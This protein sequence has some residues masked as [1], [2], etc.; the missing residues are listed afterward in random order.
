M[1]PQWHR[2]ED[3]WVLTLSG[4]LPDQ[5][6]EEIWGDKYLRVFQRVYDGT[7]TYRVRINRRRAYQCLEDPNWVALFF[8]VTDRARSKVT[9][10][11]LWRD[12]LIVMQRFG[13]KPRTYLIVVR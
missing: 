2:T 10:K 6:E 5:R 7:V 12:K 11:R 3:G 1:D 4:D 13:L 8:G 9:G